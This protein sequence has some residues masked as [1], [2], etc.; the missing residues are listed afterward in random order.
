ML[1]FQLVLQEQAEQVLPAHQVLQVPLEPVAEVTEV[2]AVLLMA[3]EQEEQADFP[4]GNHQTANQ[5]LNELNFKHQ[6]LR[7]GRPRKKIV[8]LYEGYEGMKV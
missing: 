5:I 2:F 3:E 6:R 4:G 8:V 1:L 7:A